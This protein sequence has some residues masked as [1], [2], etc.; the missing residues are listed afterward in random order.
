MTTASSH[1]SP[2]RAA[3]IRSTRALVSH[4]HGTL[5]TPLLLRQALPQS[6]RELD[7]RHLCRLRRALAHGAQEG[8]ACALIEPRDEEQEVRAAQQLVDDPCGVGIKRI[9]EV[10][11]IPEECAEGAADHRVCAQDGYGLCGLVVVS[12]FRVGSFS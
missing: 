3:S 5:I 4:G 12:Q 8:L 10:S 2:A 11:V 9:D 6:R 1:P 7:H